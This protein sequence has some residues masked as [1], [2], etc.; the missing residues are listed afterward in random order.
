M[1]N[2]IL[3]SNQYY[4]GNDL[5]IVVNHTSDK[6]EDCLRTYFISS[7]GISRHVDKDNLDKCLNGLLRFDRDAIFF[8][9]SRAICTAERLLDIPKLSDNIRKNLEAKLAEWV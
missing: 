5:L 7:E 4:C 8:M 9:K 6:R 3:V 1:V 2:D